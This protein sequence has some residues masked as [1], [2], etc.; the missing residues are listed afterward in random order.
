M[1]IPGAVKLAMPIPGACHWLNTWHD[2][3]PLNAASDF[4]N[5]RFKVQQSSLWLMV[6]MHGKLPVSIKKRSMV[7]DAKHSM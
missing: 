1:R 2:L 7:L 4:G 5:K 6:P 3:A